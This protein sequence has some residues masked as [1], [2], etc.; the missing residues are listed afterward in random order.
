MK[1]QENDN[2]LLYFK[3]IFWIDSGCNDLSSN[4]I[5]Q[6]KPKNEKR[7][8]Q[9]EEVGNMPM[10]NP[11]VFYFIIGFIIGIIISGTF[12]I[13]IIASFK[14]TDKGR[15]NPAHSKKERT[16]KK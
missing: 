4:R 16:S 15:S 3:C 13:F 6:G 9:K 8:N 2:I 12:I 11:D 7:I 5:F 10:K 14:P 1:G